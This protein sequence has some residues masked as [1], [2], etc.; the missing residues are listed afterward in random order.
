MKTAIAVPVTSG[1]HHH[2][3]QFYK[4]EAVPSIEHAEN[5]RE[6]RPILDADEETLGILQRHLKTF[7]TKNRQRLVVMSLSVTGILLFLYW[8][9]A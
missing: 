2:D 3:H 8:A 1:Q 6:T 5:Y 9:I 4:Y 7:R